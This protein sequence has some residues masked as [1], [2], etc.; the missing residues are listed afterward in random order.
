MVFHGRAGK[1]DAVGGL[2]FA[3][4]LRGERLGVF[5]ILGLVEDEQVPVLFG[6]QLE[7]AGEQRIGGED[8]VGLFDL[9]EQGGA[10]QSLE[11]EHLEL[12]REFRGF[13]GPVGDDRGGSDDE[14]WQAGFFCA[15]G[16]EVGEGLDGFAEAHVVGED[17]VEA[18]G[19][20][21]LEPAVAFR[22]IGS[23]L[24]AEG[25]GDFRRRQGGDVLEAVAELGEGA[26]GRGGIDGQRVGHA[27]GGEAVHPDRAVA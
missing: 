24:G 4:V 10:L 21:E 2:E 27:G 9:A 20:E 12:G 22:L 5:D 13:I 19:G 8:D 26:G 3:G 6:E 17:A 16:G 11:D 23:E 1:A 15:L 25:I 7:I 14:R 18:V